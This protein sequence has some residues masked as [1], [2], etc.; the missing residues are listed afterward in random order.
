MAVYTQYTLSQCLGLLAFKYDQV[1]FWTSDE[2]TDAINEGLLVWNSLTGFWKETITIPTTL[3]AN[4]DYALPAS[5]VFGM[6]VEY[7]GKPLNLS[8][9]DDM[10]N[11]HPGWQAQ[12]SADGGNVP[13]EPKNWLPLSV[14]MIAIWPADA[15]G[16]HT[17]TIDG[18]AATPQLTAAGDFIDIGAEELGVILGYALHVLSLK[19]GGA[20]F[21]ATQPYFIAFLQAAAEEND[22]LTQSSMFREFLGLDLKRQTTETRGKPTAYD[23]MSGRKP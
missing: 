9:L 7:E 22:Q 17:L 2:A 13:N 4:W 11:G 5:I 23:Q 20:R 10:D 12:T 3:T 6:R 14:D 1:P 15:V 8:S 21:A 16:G 19:E 18:V